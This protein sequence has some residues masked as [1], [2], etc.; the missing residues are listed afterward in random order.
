MNILRQVPPE[1]WEREGRPALPEAPEQLEQ[2]EAAAVLE[3]GYVRQ[4]LLEVADGAGRD[5]LARCLTCARPGATAPAPGSHVPPPADGGRPTAEH[6]MAHAFLHLPGHRR[7]SAAALAVAPRELESVGGAPGY[8]GQPLLTSGPLS[9]PRPPSLA[10]HGLLRARSHCN[11]RSVPPLTR[12]TPDSLR[13]SVALSICTS[14][15]HTR[16]TKRFS[17]RISETTM[18]PNPRSARGVRPQ[19]RRRGR[20]GGS[21]AAVAA[22]P[23]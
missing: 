15:R 7:R 19:R 6:L 22:D 10:P 9:S 4:R 11:C 3:P 20:Y 8:W 14:V 17:A 2:L 1:A 21:G 16:F 5:F 18:R 13:D 12:F 23:T